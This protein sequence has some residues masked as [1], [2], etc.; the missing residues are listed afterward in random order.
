[1]RT[2]QEEARLQALTERRRAKNEELTIF[3][4]RWRAELDRGDLPADEFDTL[5]RFRERLRELDPHTALVYFLPSPNQM[6]TVL[7]SGLGKAQVLRQK[8]P[9]QR[10]TWILE[11]RD[12]LRNRGDTQPSARKLYDA[13]LRPIAA[14]LDAGGVHRGSGSARPRSVTNESSLLQLRHSPPG[15]PL[16]PRPAGPLITP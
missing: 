10:G 13:L 3:L 16:T 9:A 12:A 8:P 11:Y 14:Q 15:L 1:V 5:Q 6:R 7:T 2:P 4:A